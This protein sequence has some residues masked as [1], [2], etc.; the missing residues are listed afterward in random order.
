[1]W[2]TRRAARAELDASCAK[3]YSLDE[4]DLRYVPDPADVYRP[5]FSGE[6][7][8]VLKGRRKTPVSA[9]TAPAR[10]FLKRGSGCR[11]GDLT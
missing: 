4:R 9:I 11:G 10:W 8:R 6:T 2:A 7:F 1:V 3:L 5:D